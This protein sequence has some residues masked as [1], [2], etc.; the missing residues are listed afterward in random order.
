[1][2]QNGLFAVKRNEK[3]TTDHIERGFIEMLPVPLFLS[4]RPGHFVGMLA[5]GIVPNDDC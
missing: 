5:F 1:M 2:L 4:W 3:K